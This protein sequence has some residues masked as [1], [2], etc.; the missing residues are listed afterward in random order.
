MRM[1]KNILVLLGALGVLGA[2]ARPMPTTAAF[3]RTLALQVFLD[4]A[5]FSPNAI[6]GA[7]GRKSQVAL[8]TYCAVKGRPVPATPEAACL[9]L[10][11][12]TLPPLAIETVTVADHAALVRIPAAPEAKSKLTAMGYETIEEMFAERGHLTQGALRRLNPTLAWPN[13]PAGAHVRLPHFG[14]DPPA[15]KRRGAKKGARVNVLRVS[16]TRRE[17]T[18]FDSDGG[19]L[20]LLPC[21]IAADKAKLPPAGEILIQAM[22][23]RPNYTYKPDFTPK[24]AKSVKHIFPPGPNNPVGVVWMGLTLAG[25]GIHGTPKPEQIGRAE[26]HGCFRL[27]NW[28]ARRLY[29]LC[30][31]GVAV[32]IEN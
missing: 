19:F 21:S 24:G 23:P 29:D 14:A 4:R 7:W 13:P 27:A 30:D 6:D 22:V 11:G 25:Y 31:P 28:N 15:P 26:S 5:G 20:L 8:A 10:V 32:V 16:L 17:I 2:V 12:A 1:A 18:A 3:E 9:E